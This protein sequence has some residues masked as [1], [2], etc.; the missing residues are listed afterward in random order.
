M[1]YI[2]AY[3]K[4]KEEFKIFSEEQWILL[5]EDDCEWEEIACGGSVEELTLFLN[6]FLLQMTN[7]E[8]N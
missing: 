4:E 1:Q 8:K 5:P 7:I 6:Q 2:L 3:S